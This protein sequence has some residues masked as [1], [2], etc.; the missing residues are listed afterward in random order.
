MKA[1]RSRPRTPPCLAADRT[2][3][4]CIMGLLLGAAC[5]PDGK[6]A[7][8]RDAVRRALQDGHR[9]EAA[10]RSLRRSRHGLLARCPVCR[11]P[12]PPPLPVI[13]PLPRLDRSDHTETN[14]WTCRTCGKALS[15]GRRQFCSDRCYQ[16]A[17]HER[18]RS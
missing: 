18:V 13:P 5:C 7:L 10:L 12:P 9:P 2:A 6:C 1:A 16:N 4:H 15:R 14:T 8:C 11:F 3:E 17:E